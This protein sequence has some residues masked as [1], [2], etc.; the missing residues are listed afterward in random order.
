MIGS[1]LRLPHEVVT[2]RIH[3]VLRGHGFDITPTE[4]GVFLY[5]GPK[6]VGR[7]YWRASAT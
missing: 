6:A 4:L 5:P 1:L 2:A 7:R 3:A